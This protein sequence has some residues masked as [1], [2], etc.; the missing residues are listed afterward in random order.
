MF[1][2]S[3][4]RTHIHTRNM[5]Q[6]TSTTTSTTRAQ[7][8]EH[9][10]TYTY[11]HT[12]TRRSAASAPAAA[13]AAFA[14]K[15]VLQSY[16]LTA[17]LPTPTSSRRFP[18]LLLSLAPFGSVGQVKTDPN[19]RIQLIICASPISHSY[20]PLRLALPCL[21]LSSATLIGGRQVKGTLRERSESILLPANA[22]AAA[23]TS[24]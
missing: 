3:H 16:P 1:G 22:A 20:A 6:A 17:A 4:R 10:N 23:A 21:S 2:C 5:K 9:S 7:P 15:N 8:T 11:T 14:K 19:N 12:H 13:A 24:P 18:P